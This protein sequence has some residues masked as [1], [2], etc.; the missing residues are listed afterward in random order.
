MSGQSNDTLS[1]TLD[2]SERILIIGGLIL[3]VG[4][5]VA[6]EVFA[7]FLS[8]AINADLRDAWMDVLALSGQGAVPEILARFDEIRSLATERAQ[9]MSLHSHFGPYGLLAAGLGL[10]RYRQTAAGK[11]DTLASIFVVSGGLFQSLGFLTMDYQTGGWINLANAGALLL[12]AGLILLAP[13][14]A[15]GKGASSALPTRNQP[16]GLLLRIGVT[17]VFAGLLFGLYLAWRHVFHEEPALHAALANLVSAIQSGNSAAAT[18]LYASY[19]SAQI[20][21][22]I[23]AASHSHTVGFG[24][25]M[26]VAALLANHLPPTMSQWRHAAFLL[27][28]VGGILLPLFVYL[29]PRFG[30]IYA[31]C[32]DTAGGLVIV[33]LLI[34]ITGL[35]G[36]GEVK[37]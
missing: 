17:L 16:G 29:A 24:F 23:T 15:K 34:V 10:A 3:I 32:A 26:I 8:H 4:G 9:A 22:A 12:L 13:G 21:M 25:I 18:D 2:L 28:A 33:G 36:G 11:F 30:Y 7:L 5:L 27:I 31:L 19:K 35:F 6:G 14:L 37:S 20:T 1:R